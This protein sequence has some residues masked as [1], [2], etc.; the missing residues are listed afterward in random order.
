[1]ARAM[2]KAF[3]VPEAIEKFQ[4]LYEAGQLNTEEK[5]E[6]ADYLTSLNLPPEDKLKHPSEIS[7]G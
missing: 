7:G 4:G 2:A 3:R 6:Y 1:M 5:L